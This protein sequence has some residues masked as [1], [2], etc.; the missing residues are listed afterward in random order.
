M[1]EALR[2]GCQDSSCR[3]T[4]ASG[5][6]I[7]SGGL[8]TPFYCFHM[9]LGHPRDRFCSMAS[10]IDLV[11]FWGC[12]GAACRLTAARRPPA[13]SAPLRSLSRGHNLREGVATATWPRS[14]TST[15]ATV[16]AGLSRASQTH[17]SLE[18]RCYMPCQPEID[19]VAGPENGV[20]TTDI[21]AILLLIT[22]TIDPRGPAMA[23]DRCQGSLREGAKE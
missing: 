15:A 3:R 16:W 1:M 9:V 22:E 19:L 18:F 6:D 2:Y 8:A 7:T 20:H 4:G 12:H 11:T 13:S 5:A 21:I 17:T 10:S 23:S 14:S